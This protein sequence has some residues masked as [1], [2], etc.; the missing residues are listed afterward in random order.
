MKNISKKKLEKGLKSSSRITCQNWLFLDLLQR[1]ISSIN[2]EETPTALQKIP[3]Y[4]L[5]SAYF[6]WKKFGSE[7]ATPEILGKFNKKHM[8][9]FT[10]S[11][12][13]PFRRW[14]NGR[15]KSKSSL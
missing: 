6:W 9:F 7:D 15:E 14:K 8:N 3:K 12:M 4:A 2:L 1:K 5:L 13:R 11:L 10:M